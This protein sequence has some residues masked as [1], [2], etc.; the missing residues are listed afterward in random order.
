MKIDQVL[1]D[2]KKSGFVREQL[3]AQCSLGL[4]DLNLSDGK[5]VL[6]LFPHRISYTAET[7]AAF[8]PC[9]I[10]ELAY[11][12]NRVERFRRLTTASSF[13]SLS[14]DQITQAR[15]SLETL[16]FSCDKI[17]QEYF[18]NSAV[19][20]DHLEEHL[21]SFQETVG[22]LGLERIYGMADREYGGASE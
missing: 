15:S 5:L 21:T 2:I 12:F 8:M 1:K 11:P 10:L 13:V 18:E 3:P 14:A 7:V 9:C 17:L 20:K 4:P 16:Y 6:R 22:V 19:S